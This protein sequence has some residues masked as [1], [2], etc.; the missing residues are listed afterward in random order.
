[1]SSETVHILCA[2]NCS[3]SSMQNRGWIEL[4]G[5]RFSI[6]RPAKV[7]VLLCEVNIHHWLPV[8]CLM[9][10]QSCSS[11]LSSSSSSLFNNNG[12]LSLLCGRPISRI[13]RLARLSVVPYGFIT[14]KQKKNRKLRIGINGPQGT[15]KRSANF[16]LKRSKIKVTRCQKPRGIAAYLA[17]MF[18]YSGADCKL[19][20]TTVRLN[21]LLTPETLGNWTDGR[22][23]CR[24]SAPTIST[25]CYYYYH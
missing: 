21:L 16:H 25:R 5:P 4:E 8:C 17:Y 13:T 11:V 14:Q 18:T 20:L 19:G 10:H 12:W 23:S 7:C 22:V 9:R 15:S 3:R 2:Q 24:H 1:L 6:P